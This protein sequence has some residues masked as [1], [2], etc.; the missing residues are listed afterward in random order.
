[1]AEAWEGGSLQVYLE[2]GSGK[3]RQADSL[4]GIKLADCRL[5]WVDATAVS[6]QQATAIANFFNIHP[7]A[8]QQCAKSTSLPKV[9]EFSD[10]LFIIWKF[11]RDKPR[12][13]AIETENIC[14][15]LGSNFL[16][17]LHQEELEE[18]KAVDD[19]LTAD[20]A[21][22]RGQ[23]STLLYAILDSAVDEYFPIVEELTQKIDAYM[24]KVVTGNNVGDLQTILTLKHRNMAM[25]RL[26]A[27]HSEAL[28]KL[29]RRDVPFIPDDMAVYLL[30]VYDHL[31]RIFSEVD[32]NSD[33]I[34]SS[35]DI[36]LNQVS[37]RLNVTMKRL[38]GIAMIFMPLT[39]LVGIWGMNLRMPETS[40]HYGYLF[41][42]LLF[43]V[44]AGVMVIT[45]I[46]KD[47]F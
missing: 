30:D 38:A 32:N 8:M 21:V 29:A 43:L 12:S 25:R 20:P 36:H 16:V 17:T 42:W 5:L 35:L 24:E 1:M 26:V 6:D 11:V 18:V 3:S 9:Q 14:L 10:H 23:P 13:E 34:T 2:D 47:W 45:G 44:I 7:L 28:M 41:A 22:Y 4:E 46:R 40:W 19:K 33:L 27:S 31:V 15:F 39:F 37:N